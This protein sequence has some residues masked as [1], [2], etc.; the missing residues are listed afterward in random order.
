VKEIYFYK[1]TSGKEIIT[2][3]VDDLDEITRSRV[4]NSIRLLEKYGLELLGNQSVKKILK[5]PDIFELRIV[6]SKQVRILFVK[7]D[8][9][10]YLI[11]H[12]FVKRT[13]KTPIKEMKLARKRAKEYI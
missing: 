7:Y 6:G 2:N 5:K 13:Q 1:T 9:N 3:F 11:V 8:I 10:T 4:R 12:I